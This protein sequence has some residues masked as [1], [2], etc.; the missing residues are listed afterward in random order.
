MYER[1]LVSRLQAMP[2]RLCV[3]A[4]GRAQVPRG[5]PTIRTPADGDVERSAHHGKPLII[6]EGCQHHHQPRAAA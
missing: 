5:R 4:G 1:T 3:T 2:R 6:N